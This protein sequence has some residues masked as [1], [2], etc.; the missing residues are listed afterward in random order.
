MIY[1]NNAATTVVKPEAVKT[2]PKKGAGEAEAKIA[3]L[4]GCK[5]SVILTESGSEALR[6][7]VLSF[8]RPK[9][10]IIATDME[11]GAALSVLKELEEAGCRVTYIPT[12]EY[13]ALRVDMIE[14]AIEEDT[15]AM[16]CCH[17]SNV[18]GNVNDLEKISA[19]AR[20][21]NIRLISD[22]CQ[23]AGAINV[24]L[25]ELGVDAYC[26]TGHK[27]L[28]GPYGTGGIC[29]RQG[30]SLKPEIEKSITP[31]DEK[32]LGRL[33]AAIDFIEEKGIYGI[34][35]FP[36]RLAKRF[37]ESVKS[38]K[39]VTVYGDFGS[40]VRIPTV[41]ISLRGHDAKEVKEHMRKNGIVVKTGDFSAPRMVKALEAKKEG[42]EGLVRF[43]FGYFNTRRDV[44]D[45]VWVIMEILGI[46][47]LYL[48]A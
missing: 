8:A 17:G 24:N 31:P 18:T 29:L 46:D 23:T 20:R 44:N 1:L 33:C 34:S 9:S 21:H 30:L 7:A 39:D 22:G 2:A 15:S 40:N 47:D 27:K 28:M 35:I 32:K 3:K 6:A 36:H 4:L 48:L 11:Y 16:V 42:N 10:H 5:G 37:F 12:D 13:G 19:M 14:D 25:E 38:M 45:T 41:S 26:F 43:S